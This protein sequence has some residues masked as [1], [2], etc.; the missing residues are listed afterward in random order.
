[1]NI[2]I[3]YFFIN[4]LQAFFFYKSLIEFE[5]IWLRN[6]AHAPPCQCHTFPQWVPITMVT[7]ICFYPTEAPAFISMSHFLYKVL[8]VPC[9]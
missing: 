2:V 3:L 5:P 4:N 6:L 1:M 9:A 8:I 7:V